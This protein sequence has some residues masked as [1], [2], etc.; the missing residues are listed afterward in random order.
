MTLRAR[1]TREISLA[2]KIQMNPAVALILA[3]SVAGCLTS[4]EYFGR[5]ADSPQP[6]A[7]PSRDARAVRQV[8]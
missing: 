5:P 1:A 7:P 2:G 4:A 6:G 8:R 3:T